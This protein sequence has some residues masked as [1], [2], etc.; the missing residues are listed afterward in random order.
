MRVDS[1]FFLQ[2][3]NGKIKEDHDMPTNT[4]FKLPQ[5]KQ[6]QIIA[7]AIE[8]FLCYKDNYKQSSINRIA[9]KAGVSVGGLYRYFK[10]KHDIFL[11]IYELYIEYPEVSPEADSLLTF[12][13]KK[14]DPDKEKTP[15]RK[16]LHT[17][18]DIML[19]N[20]DELLY[21]LFFENTTKSKLFH[22]IVSHLENDRSCGRLR[23][24]INSEEAA[25]LYLSLEFLSYNYCEEKGLSSEMPKKIT[26]DITDIFFHGIYKNE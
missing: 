3:N 23:D 25:F 4:F 15:D 26:A 20:K 19:K 13:Q 5:K 22:Q 6:Q 17:L 10:D 14:M 18:F 9:E 1:H 11:Y 2:Y 8:E 16:L 24:N 12:Y 21:P 7:A